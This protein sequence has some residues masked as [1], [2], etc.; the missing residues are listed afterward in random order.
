MILRT[1]DFK[2]IASKI[3]AAVDSNALSA[4]TETLE[5]RAENK[6]L[7]V[8]VTNREYYV[9]V[10]LPLDEEVDFRATVN[11][12]L[13]LNLISQ[14]T[15]DCIEL[16]VK[17]QYLM[18]KGNGSYK[19][20][21]IYDGDSLLKLPTISIDN[22][23]AEMDI[24]AEVLLSISK[25]NVK[26]WNKG[27][28]S[29]AVQRYC[30]MDEKGAI[31]FISGA[32]VNTFSLTKPVKVLLN[33]R[34]VKLFKLF[35]TGLV[36][37]TLGYDPAA[38]N[39]EIIQ[40]KVKFESPSISLTAIVSCDDTLLESFPVEAIRGRALEIYPYSVTLNRENL[41]QTINRLLL[42][43][44]KLSE[45]E[46]IKNYSEVEF[47]TNSF[48]MYDVKKDNKETVYY[49]NSTLSLETPYTAILDLIDLKRTLEACTDQYITLNFGD[50]IAMVISRQHIYN[51]IPEIHSV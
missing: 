23:T 48:V 2:D 30:Y 35:S 51:V 9:E 22:P 13:F 47:G 36:K 3:L 33:M 16:E 42:F 46:E 34:L 19:F 7:K 1:E 40:T 45:E 21:L 12:N 50:E 26:E 41:L 37:F 27:T 39:S 29:S 17:N 44:S 4:V 49:T 25:Y 32:C 38:I 28:I 10:K 11:A 6:Y 15:T 31:T 5:I 18:V 24:P 43:S 14:I 8:C 20:P